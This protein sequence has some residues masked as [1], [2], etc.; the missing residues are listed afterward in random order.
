MMRFEMKNL[1]L[2][3]IF[4]ITSILLIGQHNQENV[5]YIEQKEITVLS[6]RNS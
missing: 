3:I 5:D 1:A 6:S 4:N 2:L